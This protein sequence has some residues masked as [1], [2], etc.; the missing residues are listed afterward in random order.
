M[1]DDFTDDHGDDEEFVEPESVLDELA[2][3]LDAEVLSGSI[4]RYRHP[5]GTVDV[6]ATYSGLWERAE[7]GVLRWGSKRGAWFAPADGA[8][9]NQPT[10]Y[11]LA[12][13]YVLAHAFHQ[14][15]RTM[16][17]YPPIVDGLYI[18]ALFAGRRLGVDD[19]WAGVIGMPLVATRLVA[20]SLADESKR[21]GDDG[22]TDRIRAAVDVQWTKDGVACIR[23]FPK[24]ATRCRSA[25]LDL[26]RYVNRFAS[27]HFASGMRRPL[28]DAVIHLGTVH[29]SL[30]PRAVLHV[31]RLAMQHQM[32]QQAESRPSQPAPE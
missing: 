16:A 22:L 5:D 11:N 18:D 27:P 31:L 26:D 8:G 1:T 29:R 10:S 21:D 25:A 23:G 17:Q 30:Y 7:P 6:V 3:E 19:R 14:A 13:G 2:V 12:C 28:V 4:T 24:A 9:S 15:E 20:D 32:W